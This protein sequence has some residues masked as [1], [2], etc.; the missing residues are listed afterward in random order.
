MSPQLARYTQALLFI[1]ISL[2]ALKRLR[3]RT[4]AERLSGNNRTLR[5][6]V[7]THDGI[8]PLDSLSLYLKTAENIIFGENKMNVM[9]AE[10]S[11]Y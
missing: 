7:E 10:M 2:T 5:R 9:Q 1:N 6:V 11:G 4:R 8:H 3:E